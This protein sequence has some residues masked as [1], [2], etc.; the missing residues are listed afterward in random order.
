MTEQLFY[1]YQVT[2]PRDLRAA[3]NVLLDYADLEAKGVEPKSRE[4]VKSFLADLKR[5][6]RLYY[7]RH[8]RPSPETLVWAKDESMTVRFKLPDW[9][10][11]REQ[12]EDYFEDC[13]RMECRPSMYDCTGQIFTTGY[14]IAQWRGGEWWC[15]H[16]IAMDV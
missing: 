10:E 15:W 13:I 7:K 8:N 2:S 1:V 12:A 11:T 9:I 6:I 14:H 3:Y 5:D 4:G 16:S